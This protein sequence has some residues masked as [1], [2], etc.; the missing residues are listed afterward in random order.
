VVKILIDEGHPVAREE[1]LVLPGNW[2]LKAHHGVHPRAEFRLNQKFGIGAVLAA[3]VGDPIMYHYNLAM[4]AKVDSALQRAQQRIAYR[5]V[6]AV[7]TPAA[8]IACQC[9]ERMIVREPRSSAIARQITLRPAAR[10]RASTTLRPLW[11]GNQM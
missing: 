11:S 7:R 8:R 6:A 10:S 9:L 2:T 5:Q 4:V 3:A 1:E